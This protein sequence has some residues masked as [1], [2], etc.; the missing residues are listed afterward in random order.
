MVFG[1]PGTTN[2]H[3]IS[4]ELDYIINTIRPAQIDM[5]DL[6]LSVINAAMKKSEATEIMY[7]SKQARIANAWKK[8][9]GQIDGLK[10]GDAVTKK[11]TKE[12]AYTDLANTKSVWK[13]EYGTVVKE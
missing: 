9:M 10:R 12:D 5:R 2:Q 4:T 6:S 3:T 8:W 13:T 1:F 7:A 11:V